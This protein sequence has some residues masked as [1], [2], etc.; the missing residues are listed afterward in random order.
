MSLTPPINSDAVEITVSWTTSLVVTT[1]PELRA[2]PEPHADVQTRTERMVN[3]AIRRSRM[4][5][6][7]T[8]QW[9]ID[10]FRQRICQRSHRPPDGKDFT[11]RTLI[12]KLAAFRFPVA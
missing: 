11:Q 8:M 1:S 4:L 7:S 12:D 2:G 10:G 9:A 3:E 5:C 6:T